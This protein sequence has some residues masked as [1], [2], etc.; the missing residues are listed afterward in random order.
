[1]T[2]LFR[3]HVHLLDTR[4]ITASLLL[5]GMLV[6][7]GCGQPQ[8][9]N[10]GSPDPAAPMQPSAS[11]PPANVTPVPPSAGILN[12]PFIVPPV[13]DPPMLAAEDANLS[14]DEIVI[15]V[16]D[17]AAPRAWLVS[18]LSNTHSHVV[19]DTRRPQPLAV[20]SCDRS[21]CSRV[22]AGQ[23]GTD[24]QVQTAGFVNGEMWLRVDGRMLPQS[25]FEIPLADQTSTCTSWKDWTAAHPDTSV[26]V[27]AVSEPAQ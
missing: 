21:R 1:M 2:H 7:A 12:T 25:S 5:G 14:P 9:N 16:I 20:T 17:E 8:P 26:Y 27:G 22:L 13:V 19:I 15:G 18:A 24:L 4:L 10:G 6:N 23:P 3:G 11:A